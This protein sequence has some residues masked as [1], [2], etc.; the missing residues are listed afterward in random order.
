MFLVLHTLQGSWASEGAGS[1][2]G[3]TPN[4][5]GGSKFTGS[6]REFFWD[7]Q[8]SSGI[9]SPF[10]WGRG[11]LGAWGGGI[12]ILFLGSTTAVSNPGWESL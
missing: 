8:Y 5:V 12:A 4:F 7:I 10:G 6:L 11:G 1:R 3:D 9:R 2:A